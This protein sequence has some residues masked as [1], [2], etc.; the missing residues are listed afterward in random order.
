MHPH[1]INVRIVRSIHK[2]CIIVIFAIRRIPTEYRINK[3]FPSV[4][5][6]PLR[7]IPNDVSQ[8]SMLRIYSIVVNA[9]VIL[10]A[11]LRWPMVVNYFLCFGWS[12]L[13]NEI[14]WHFRCHQSMRI[15]HLITP[16]SDWLSF[17]ISYLSWSLMNKSLSSRF[18]VLWIRKSMS[19]KLHQISNLTLRIISPCLRVTNNAISIVCRFDLI[20]LTF[21]AKKYSGSERYLILWKMVLQYVDSK[22]NLIVKGMNDDR[23]TKNINK[24]ALSTYWF[25]GRYK[26]IFSFAVDIYCIRFISTNI[27]ITMDFVSQEFVAD[28]RKLYRLLD[29]WMTNHRNE[30]ELNRTLSPILSV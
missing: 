30:F 9:V 29:I 13:A 26:F 5:S 25:M 19:C 22:T 17:L 15:H 2:S 10:F 16:C 20:F 11:R 6:F 4:C 12:K 8:W 3:V 28:C 7:F 1:E 24:I 27:D 14:Y 21:I 18:F 23:K